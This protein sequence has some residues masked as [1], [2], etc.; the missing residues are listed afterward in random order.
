M[1]LGLKKK[2]V[3]ISGASRGLGYACARLFLMEGATVIINS[4]S[5]DHL[6]FAKE[7]LFA[8]T[9]KEPLIYMGDITEREFSLGVRNFIENS[10]P[11]LDILLTNSGGPP[12]GSIESLNDEQWQFSVELAFLGH[13]R[14]IRSCLPLLRK[15]TTPSILTITS[16]SVKQ[17]I[18]NLLLSNSIRAATIGLTKS[19]ALEFGAENI[20]INSI[21]PGSTNTERLSSLLENRA[22]A[23]NT[24]QAE[25]QLKQE[26]EIALH[27][28]ASPEEFARVAVFLASP[29]ASYLTGVMISVDGGAIKGIY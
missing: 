5:I 25:E 16:S 8:E 23:N 19:L 2:V 20:R 15:S 18:A 1:D 27:R 7:N 11:Q 24:S 12:P 4:R 26:N 28:L 29:A 9:G 17:P 22:L 14:L 3:F 21:L 10:F 6:K 13:M